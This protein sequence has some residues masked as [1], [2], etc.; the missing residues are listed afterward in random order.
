[1]PAGAGAAR[2][3]GAKGAYGDTRW[4]MAPPTVAHG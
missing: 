2:G 1:M 3:I 4:E